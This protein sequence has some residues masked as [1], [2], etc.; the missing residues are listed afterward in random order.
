MLNWNPVTGNMFH[1]NRNGISDL[2]ICIGSE[3]D[4]KLEG[5]FLCNFGHVCKSWFSFITTNRTYL[6]HVSLLSGWVF[7]YYR[8]PNNNGIDHLV[9]RQTGALI[10]K[11]E[12]IKL[13]QR[14]YFSTKKIFL[15]ES[16]TRLVCATAIWSSLRIL[17]YAFGGC[18]AQPW[19][20][21]TWSQCSP[22]VRMHWKLLKRAFYAG[23][24]SITWKQSDSGQWKHILNISESWILYCIDKQLLHNTKLEFWH[25]EW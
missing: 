24:F 8:N 5:T 23:C 12:Y 9:G 18:N 25:F 1:F 19:F 7:D 6:C 21:S 3:I 2:D 16:G 10:G 14:F 11:T 15:C 22:D 4:E 17:L 20:G 13:Y